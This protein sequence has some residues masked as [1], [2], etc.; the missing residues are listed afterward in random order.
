MGCITSEKLILIIVINGFSYRT[1]FYFSLFRKILDQMCL[2]YDSYLKILRETL[3]WFRNLSPSSIENFDETDA[4]NLVQ[5]VPGLND[6]LILFEEMKQL[7]PAI[8][9]CQSMNKVLSMFKLNNSSKYYPRA[10][11]L[12]QFMLT[13]PVT[14][15][16]NERSFSKLKL[17]KNYLRSTM[18]ND[19]LFYLIISSIESDLLDEIDIKTLVNDWSKMKDRRIYVKH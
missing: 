10:C 5:I 13:L 17:I 14:V 12:Y 15:A 4:Q 18:S 19:R 3:Y 6:S 16:S 2:E 11:L 9:Q 8:A 7:T 1:Q